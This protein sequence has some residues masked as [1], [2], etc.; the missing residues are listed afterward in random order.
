MNYLS[1]PPLLS[2]EV[3]FRAMKVFVEAFWE[4]GGRSSDGLAMLLGSLDVDPAQRAD[5][6]DA[7]GRVLK[8]DG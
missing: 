3:A 1:D 8:D 5:W 2:E 6:T 7:V 4:R